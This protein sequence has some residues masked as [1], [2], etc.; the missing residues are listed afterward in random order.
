MV[1]KGKL[2]PRGRKTERIEA[3]AELEIGLAIAVMAE[4]LAGV[5]QGADVP[6][7]YRAEAVRALIAAGADAL[8]VSE[9]ANRRADEI[10]HEG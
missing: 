3:V 10:R 2:Q 6:S 9:E 4:R 8:G 5:P 7:G 1:G